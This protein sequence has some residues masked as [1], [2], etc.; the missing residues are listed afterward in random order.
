MSVLWTECQFTAYSASTVACASIAAALR[1]T[2]GS[3]PGAAASADCLAR[4]QEATGAD[5]VSGGRTRSPDTETN[6]LA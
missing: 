6:V 3:A 5:T 1:G 2:S 4:L